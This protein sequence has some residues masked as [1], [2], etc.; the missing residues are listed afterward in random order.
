MS[1]T[2]AVNVVAL[3]VSTRVNTWDL[4]RLC[5]R[6]DKR[7]RREIC[8]G[9]GDGSF[10]CSSF[11][12]GE[13]NVPRREFCA[14]T[15]LLVTVLLALLRLWRRTA[16][17]PRLFRFHRRV[18]RCTQRGLCVV[19]WTDLCTDLHVW[20][21]WWDGC[22]WVRWCTRLWYYTD[23]VTIKRFLSLKESKECL[24]HGLRRVFTRIR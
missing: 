13:I 6:D 24:R 21:Y 7:G 15:L 8:S 9:S 18:G 19:N 5:V 10:V 20:I 3:S 23:A 11:S 2:L 22:W 14:V 16:A 1:R 4:W 17:R 12:S